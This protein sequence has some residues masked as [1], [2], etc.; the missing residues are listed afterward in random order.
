VTRSAAQAWVEM[1]AAWAIPPEI[2]D[3]APESPWGFPV[4]LFAPPATPID[5]RS[6]RRALEALAD[7]GSVLDVGCGGGAASM[8]LVPPARAVTGVD[9]GD[10]MLST[11]AAAADE[12]GVPHREVLGS[13]LEV[14]ATVEPED[15]VVCHHV[16]YNVPDLTDFV[17]AL[18]DHSRRRVVCELTANHPQSS[19]NELWRHFWGIERPAGPTFEDAVAVVRESGVEPAVEQWQRVPRAAGHTHEFGRADEVAFA[20]RRLCLTPDH[21]AELDR[22]LPRDAGVMP[23]DVVTLWWDV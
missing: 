10:H 15:V 3:A 6:R 2:L 16:F 23:Q 12:R 8:A 13:W 22:L 21:D 14:A 4:P 19:L 9:T 17:R 5:T 1:L 7:D 11:F 20:R 18:T